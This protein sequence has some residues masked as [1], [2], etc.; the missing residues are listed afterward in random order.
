MGRPKSRVSKVR[1]VGPL[2]PFVA[3]FEDR[4]EAIGYTALSS[5]VQVR[6]L[7]HLSRW[8]DARQLGVPELTEEVVEEFLAARRAS[9]RTAMLTRRSLTPLLHLLEDQEVL[10]AARPMSPGPRVEVL[11]ASFHRYL[12]HERG[13]ASSTARAHV[14]RARRF[15]QAHAA[16]GELG[17]LT[18]HDVTRAVLD[19]AAT[20]SVASAQYFVVALRSFLRFCHLQG[21]VESDLSTATLPVTGRRRSPLPRGISRSD[22]EALLRSCDRQQAAGSRDYAVLVTLVRLGA[23]EVAGLTLDDIDWRA[24]EV[25]VRGK[26]RREERLPL[27]ADVGE[28]LAG[29]LQSGRPRMSRREVFLSTIAPVKGMTREAIS[30]LLRR[31]CRRAGVPPIGPHRL[32]HTLACEMVGAGVPLPE[33]GQVLRHLDLVSTA[34]YARVGV[35]QLRVLARPLASGAW[36]VSDFAR[37]ADDYLRLRRALGFKLVNPGRFLRQLV[38]YLEAAG[39]QTLTV[40]LAIAWARQLPRGK[41]AISMAHRL[42]AARG[43]AR[44]L[45][46]IDPTTEVP[47]RG[48]WTSDTR[49]PVPYLY[50]DDDVRRLL[51]AARQRARWAWS[52]RSPSRRRACVQAIASASSPARSGSPDSSVTDQH[53]T[54][55][56]LV[57]PG[58]LIASE[59]PLLHVQPGPVQALSVQLLAHR[60]LVQPDAVTRVQDV[61]DV[62]S[63]PSRVLDAQRG[64]LPEQLGVATDDAGVGARPGLQALQTLRVVGP[65]PAVH[66]PPAD[67]PVAAI[68][69]FVNA[70]GDLTHDPATFPRGQARVG[71]LGD[72]GVPPDGDRL[73]W[74]NGHRELLHHGST[75]TGGIKAVR[76]SPAQ[77]GLVVVPSS[78]PPLT[79]LANSNTAG[80]PSPKRRRACHQAAPS[81]S[82]PARAGSA[83]SS[84]P[85]PPRATATAAKPDASVGDRP[86]Y[87]RRQPR[88]VSCGTANSRASGRIPRPLTTPAS[89]RP[90]TRTSSSRRT[91]TNDGS[92]AWLTPQLVH[93]ARFTQHR[94]GPVRVYRQ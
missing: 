94:P 14:V 60:A 6:L 93:L 49:R 47:P 46:A 75:G 40:D 87:R 69:V 25:V 81:A 2:A 68:G 30:S 43:F 71:S 65:Q 13:L 12:L 50:S 89:A 57:G 74:I 45:R 90:T 11:L 36:K 85:T 56:A 64:R 58:R 44:Y 33:I 41:R 52:T 24:A 8:L 86:R 4:L 38:A 20:L 7:A 67:H 51:E 92:S 26:G 59:H 73:C 9:G 23:S 3:G 84:R 82:R 77:G 16:D 55:P 39:A 53:V 35:A 88:S 27:P 19:E 78:S 80:T 34:I 42:G 32:R 15:L 31:A 79:R 54:D 91:S 63:A 10:A 76:P 48:I 37:H 61:G 21:L 1:V 29:Y 66:G 28:A 5:V 70:C 62:S 17:K 83:D 22:T 72:Q 18:A